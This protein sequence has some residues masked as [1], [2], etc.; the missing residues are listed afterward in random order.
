MPSIVA[1]IAEDL[2]ARI[3]AGALPDGLTLAA[4]SKHYGVSFTPIRA[5]VNQLVAQRYLGKQANGRLRVP[6]RRS[7]SAIVA[8]RVKPPATIESWE[9][10]LTREVIHRSLRGD[11]SYL[12][13]EATAAQFE[14]GRTAMRQAFSRL[15][16]KGLLKHVPRYGWRVQP[17]S[18]DDL[19]AYL[20]VRETLELKALDLAKRR[21]DPADLRRMLL[22]NP[23]TGSTE[24][25]RLDNQLHAYLIEK[26]ENGYIRD[27]FDRHGLYYTA[28]FDHAAPEAR[29]VAEMAAQHRQILKALIDQDWP[30]ARQALSHHIRSQQPIIEKLLRQLQGNPAAGS[31]P[32]AKR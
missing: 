12:R 31:G 13:E 24:P 15:A 6:K 10:A 21:L 4:L 19:Q 11:A 5:A 18:T 7:T 1:N 29:A 25:P 16:G 17:F 27:F 3:R 8:A 26:A 28:L 32:W 22:G 9:A 30:R 14:V 2:R 23:Q 20:E